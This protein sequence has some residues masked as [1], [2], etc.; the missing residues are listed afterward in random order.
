MI[1]VTKLPEYIHLYL[2]SAFFASI[3]VEIFL[4]YKLAASVFVMVENNY[5][6]GMGARKLFQ[7]IQFQEL[8]TRSTNSTYM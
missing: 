4:H 7:E 3:T 1:S 2:G 6:F 5:S 8:K